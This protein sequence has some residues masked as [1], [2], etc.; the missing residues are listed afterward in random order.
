MAAQTNKADVLKYFMQYFNPRLDLKNNEGLNPMEVCSNQEILKIFVDSISKMK[1][2]L[3]MKK[4]MK[5]QKLALE[6]DS[7]NKFAEPKKS[8]TPLVDLT[9]F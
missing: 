6:R 3:I 1:Q 8:R 4:K 7:A 5:Q 9:N 2:D